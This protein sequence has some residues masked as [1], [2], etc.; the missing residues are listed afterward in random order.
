MAYAGAHRSNADF[1]TL[2]FLMSVS[3]PPTSPETQAAVTDAPLPV[4][5]V[6]PTTPGV[7][8]QPWAQNVLPFATSLTL[9]IALLIIGYATY[10]VVKHV[11]PVVQ[12][13]I[14]IP[15]STMADQDP[16]G[17]VKHTVSTLDPTRDSAQDLKDLANDSQSWA[18]KA[19]ANLNQAALGGDA[20][21]SDL[22]TIIGIG[23]N[24]SHNTGTGAGQIGN[25]ATGQLAPFG[26]PG[27]GEAAGPKSSFAGVGG[28]AHK[29]VYI[30]QA[31]GSMLSVFDDLKREL[32][33][34][35]DALKPIQSFN[36]V[37]FS[38]DNVYALDRNSLVMA[39][40]DQK[41][42]AYDFINSM[43]PVGAT[44]PIPAIKLAMSQK[45]ELVYIL[46]DGFYKVATFD[47]VIDAFRQGN[48][49]KK[50]R[51]NCIYL[52]SDDDPKLVQVLK[53]I[54]R[55]NGGVFKITAKSAF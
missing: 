29:I 8:R 45:P 48:P 30:C 12:E 40:P 32:E 11:V 19:N 36:V 10:K 52:Q 50:A 9:H 7:L 2:E 53:Q 4:A 17:G 13:Q 44:N 38:E 42:R 21:D 15:E 28:N 24:V 37:F 26:V 49:E 41:R 18:T 20:A 35:I 14:I 34:S 5:V 33:R 3:S 25:D 54:A 51:I 23:A 22:S 47:D 16:P 6:Y 43:I 46:G 31:S 39:S 27:G 55:E 1:S